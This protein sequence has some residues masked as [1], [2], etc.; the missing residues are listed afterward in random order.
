MKWENLVFNNTSK[1]FFD[2]W[3]RSERALIR[4]SMIEK[5]SGFLIVYPITFKA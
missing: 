4:I 2:L 3:K 1:A 5:I